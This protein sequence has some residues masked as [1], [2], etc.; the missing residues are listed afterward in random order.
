MEQI[1]LEFSEI[2]LNEKTQDNSERFVNLIISAINSSQPDIIVTGAT[3]GKYS[4][5]SN[6]HFISMLDQI[7]FPVIVARSFTIPGVHRLKAPIM[8][9]IHR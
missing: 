2:Y 6:Q 1:G 3:I 5:F 9:I 7:N 8:Q 4:L